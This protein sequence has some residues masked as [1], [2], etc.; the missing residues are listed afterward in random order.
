[1]RYLML[2]GYWWTSS[3]IWLVS[4]SSLSEAREP[5]LLLYCIEDHHL[6]YFVHIGVE[7]SVTFKLTSL[8]SVDITFSLTCNSTGGLV[9]SLIW[10]RDGFLLDNTGPLILT[11][12]STFSYTNVLQVNSKTTGEY[13][14]LVRG[15]NDVLLN[16][17]I[18]NVQGSKLTILTSNSDHANPF[19]VFWHI[20]A[21]SPPVNVKACLSS[22]SSLPQSRWR[23][24]GFVLLVELLPSL[25]TGSSMATKRT[26][27][28]FHLLL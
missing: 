16:S 10:T 19:F 2:M 25:A 3:S 5:T 8:D 17:T 1:M 21:A 28:F 18:F 15:P 14:C 27:L 12:A 24:A 4:I 20:S 22:T 11:D 9:S 7:Q 26:C 23:S 6:W 13:S